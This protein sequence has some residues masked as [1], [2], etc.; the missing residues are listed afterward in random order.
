M[1]FIVFKSLKKN[2][3][4]YG[5]KEDAL[6]AMECNVMWYESDIGTTLLTIQID[7]SQEWA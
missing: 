4:S 6:S 7:V 1:M 2:Q 3:T 5:W